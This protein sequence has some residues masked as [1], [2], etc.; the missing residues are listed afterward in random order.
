MT[1]AAD[2]LRA[3]LRVPLFRDG[4]ALVLNSGLTALMG[5]VYWLLAAHEFPARTLGINSAAL[6][7][8]MFLAGVS[9]LNLMSAL[10][11]FV[12]VSG[13]AAKRLVA[14]CYAISLALGALTAVVFVAGVTRW[15]P[16]LAFLQRPVFLVWFVA[17]T[18]AWCVF[19]LQDSVLTGL[20]R[21]VIVPVEN[22]VFSTAK[23]VLLLALAA[24][25]PRYGIFAS[26][27]GAVI[28]ALVPV[29]LLLFMRLLPAHARAEGV[30]ARMPSRAQLARYVSADFMAS[31]SWLAATGLMPVIVLAFAG[32]TPT[33]WFS[34]AWMVALPLFLMSANGGAALV[35]AGAREEHRVDEY[36][37]Q[38]LGQT[39]RLVVPAA[40]AL[41]AAAPL[42]L[43]LFGSAYAA[44]ATATLRLLCLAAIPNA[45][46]A[47]AV[48]A[49]RVR[50]D[51]RAVV[52]LT[53]SQ[54][55]LVLLIGVMLLR[56]GSVAGV[57]VAWLVASATVAGAVVAVDAGG[58][59]HLG[60]LRS[61]PAHRRRTRR[62]GE[63]AP[64]ILEA[65]AADGGGRAWAVHRSLR[66]LSDMAVL[67]VGPAGE[68]PCAV[69][70][71]AT[72][73]RAARSLDH[74]RWVLSALHAD[75]RL[76]AWRVMLPEIVAQGVCGGTPYLVEHLVPGR[77]GT[78]ARATPA[79]L[80]AHAAA[81]IAP[82][83]QA[84]AFEARAGAPCLR[85]WVD[86]PVEALAGRVAP[87]ALE[88]LRGEL[89]GLLGGRTLALS[90]IHGDYVPANVMVDPAAAR[91]T[92]I[93]DWERAGPE[94][95]PLVDVATILLAARMQASRRELGRVVC[96]FLGGAVWT[97]AE[98]SILDGA[99]AGLPGETVDGRAL[100]L[101][102]WL[103]HVS[104]NLG[105]ASGYATHDRWLR[106]NV[107][108]V[109]DAVARS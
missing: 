1:A 13:A 88:R 12:P 65:L 14:S 46:V 84:T 79:D 43:R 75:P 96:E 33:A 52:A 56:R 49:R 51:M 31:L 81:A 109:A 102:C 69:V 68:A 30:P 103:W 106:A 19:N 4:Y 95:L 80:V 47:L 17:A 10:L 59:R 64:H 18:M 3:Q 32:A 41:A 37:R 85:R 8:T 67:T 105:K 22:Q 7:A 82:L 39:L 44:G 35:V 29:N 104:G 61:T 21:A 91:V 26:W 71:L 9:Q 101:L 78:R 66:T 74:E 62:A 72:S 97:A 25:S 50:R 23:I 73:E 89:R 87:S 5:A 27:T 24:A 107:H 55:G 70:K 42:V 98:R 100:V 45:V 54:C 83:H 90:W 77:T 92:G 28:F 20:G 15:A 34:M 6:S 94:G 11:R 60:W 53:A 2:R 38:A 93:V 57:G 58:L 108:P 99:L 63:T 40:L 86:A 48:S 76:G 16:R 36:A